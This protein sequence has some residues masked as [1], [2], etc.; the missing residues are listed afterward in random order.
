MLT[1]YDP[2]DNSGEDD[3]ESHDGDDEENEER[4]VR[5]NVPSEE[6]PR[7]SN[8]AISDEDITSQSE[9]D[10]EVSQRGNRDNRNAPPSKQQSENIES[11]DMSSTLKKKREEDLEKGHAIK[12]QVVCPFCLHDL[13]ARDDL[14]L[15]AF[16]DSLLDT[17]I[18]LQKSV[19]SAN[20]LPPVSFTSHRLHI[21]FSEIF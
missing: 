11:T 14:Y 17:R 7:K 6:R 1:D 2:E 20:H 18:R 12:R 4:R 21:F 10:S 3:E 15:Q 13:F 8:G 9:D 5:F 16:W 19:L